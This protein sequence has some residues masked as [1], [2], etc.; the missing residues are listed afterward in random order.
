VKE[1]IR[2]DVVRVARKVADLIQEK[3]QERAWL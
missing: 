2:A 3:Y 1:G